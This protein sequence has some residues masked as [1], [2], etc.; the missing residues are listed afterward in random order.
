MHPAILF[1]NAHSVAKF[2]KKGGVLEATLRQ[3]ETN[4]SSTNDGLS[5]VQLHE[6]LTFMGALSVSIISINLYMYCCNGP[7]CYS[8]CCYCC[9]VPTTAQVHIEYLQCA[10]V[11]INHVW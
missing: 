2:E 3:F 11:I 9:A 4:T 8:L 1:Y 5:T 10:L 6:A 7:R